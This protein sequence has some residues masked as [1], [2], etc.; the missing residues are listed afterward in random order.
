MCIL[1][2]HNKEFKPILHVGFWQRHKVNS[3]RERITVFLTNAA[4]AIGYM[5]GGK[6]NLQLYIFLN[7]WKWVIDLNVRPKNIKLVQGK[8][9]NFYEQSLIFKKI[10]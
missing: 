5:G 2:K 3:T 9:E 1:M 10:N 7:S 8:Q 6:N 4:G